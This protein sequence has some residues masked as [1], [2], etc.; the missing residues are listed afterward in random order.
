MCSLSYVMNEEI[1]NHTHTPISTDD[2]STILR[3][4]IDAISR[5]PEGQAG[6]VEIY[7]EALYSLKKATNVE[8]ASILL[9]DPDR[10]MRFKFS[11]GLSESYRKSVEG[12]TPWSPE[13]ESPDP[14]IVTDIYKDES[15]EKY[16]P[17]FKAENMGALAF[18]PLLY[19]KKVIGKFMLYSRVP[20]DF[21]ADMISSL[22]IAQLVGY[23]VVRNKI[24]IERED[25]LHK[26]TEA[27]L[28]AEKAVEIRDEFLAIASHELK[29]PL[30][31][32]L[33]NFQLVKKYL[34]S[35]ENEFPKAHLMLHLFGN[36]DHQFEKFMRLVD[37]LLDVSR[38]SAGSF[39]ITKEKINLSD[40]IKDILNRF[41]LDLKKLEYAVDK[42]IEDNIYLNADAIKLEQV[43]NNLIS[44]AIKYGLGNPISITFKRIKDKILFSITDHGIGI[45]K[46]D[47][48][49]LFNRFE[50]VSSIEYY[51]GL[52]LGLYISKN[53]IQAH[54]GQLAVDSEEGKWTTF[55]VEFPLTEE[56]SPKSYDSL[57]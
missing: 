30:T 18:I 6:L 2:L 52:G 5:A 20:Y 54:G 29:T 21:T 19:R 10:V 34:K 46:P 15:L 39:T 44:N 23:A 36:V 48:E 24:E 12:H 32:L 41:E 57:H 31:P 1:L 16:Y 53:I 13:D 56:I 25:L 55:T 22:A 35:M 51:G 40:L 11:L 3:Q 28:Y 43:F 42:N 4:L 45:A 38:I 7:K 14:I 27:R 8:R 50:R 17:I 47:F 49:K 37:N 26:E 33:L 9:F